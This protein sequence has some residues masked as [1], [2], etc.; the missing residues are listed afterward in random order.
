MLALPKDWKVWVSNNMGNKLVYTFIFLLRI[1]LN[2][3]FSVKT[4]EYQLIKIFNG[5]IGVLI[6]K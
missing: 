1:N 6:H 4:I 3:C 5:Y 2:K